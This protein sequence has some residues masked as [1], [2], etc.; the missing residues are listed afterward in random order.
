[1]QNQKKSRKWIFFVGDCITKDIVFTGVS[2]NQRG[3]ARYTM[4]TINNINSIN[5]YINLYK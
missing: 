2:K 3:K 4:G 5:I 1:M